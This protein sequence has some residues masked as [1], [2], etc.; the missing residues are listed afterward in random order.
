MGVLQ[1]TSICAIVPCCRKPLGI[2][3]MVALRQVGHSEEAYPEQVSIRTARHMINFIF[4]SNVTLYLAI[5]IYLN[6]Y[7][8]SCAYEMDG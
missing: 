1:H 5:S 8:H 7:M 4:K 6:V 3:N 2:H